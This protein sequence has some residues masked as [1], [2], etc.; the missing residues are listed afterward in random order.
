[1]KVASALLTK[2]KDTKVKEEGKKGKK[3]KL[4]LKGAVKKEKAVAAILDKSVRL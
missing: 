4:K 2:P 3:S 1:M